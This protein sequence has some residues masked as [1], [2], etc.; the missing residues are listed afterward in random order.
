MSRLA[1]DRAGNTLAIV[2]AAL[3]PLTAM[4]GS[5]VDMSRA[6][7]AK[8]RL[9][10]A[11]DAA[12][13]AGRRVMVSDTINQEVRDEAI[14]FFNFNFA[15]GMYGT[16]AFTP[17]VTR[18]AVGTVRVEA[19]TTI[20]TTIMSLFGFTTIDLE[21]EC[22]ATQNFVNTDVMLVLDTT[23]SMLCTPEELGSCGRTS[24]IPESRI[25]VLRDAVMSLYEALEPAQTQLQA[26]GMRLRY[27]IVPYSSAVNVGALIRQ[28]NPAYL[29]DSVTYPSRVANYTDST[30]VN[31]VRR[32]E[33]EDDTYRQVAFDTSQFKLGNPVTIATN[34]GGTVAAQGSYS[35]QQLAT[36]ATGVSTTSVTWNGCIMERDTVST[37]TASSG[38]TIP[39]DA[40]DLNINL[41][42]NSDA[43]RWR[44]MWP[45]VVH[46]RSGGSTSAT[47]GTAMSSLAAAWY[48]CPS[49]ARRL[50]AMTQD[51]MQDYVDN[52][53]AVGGTYHD[54]GM[55]WGARLISPGGIF[56]DSPNTFNSMPVGRHIIF[57]TDGDLAPNC[58]SYTSYGIE[59]NDMR[60][61]GGGSCPQ[62]EPRHLQRFKMICNAAKGLNVSIWVIAFG[63]GTSLT[64]D[65]IDCASNPD[66]AST[67]DNRREL[68]DR[69]TLIGQ[70]IGALRLT[71]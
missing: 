61:T 44:P 31:G 37:I 7:M 69:F 70:N 34:D 66:Q 15:Q 14:E 26:A 65:L 13:L 41:I 68:I 28:A 57:M 36:A 40:Y 58:N 56:A 11:C 47:S 9:Q 51:E 4:I 8:T 52:L 59:Q 39:P 30:T 32:Y 12:A 46:R 6:Y 17:T 5:G 35:Q 18:P 22:D 20:P 29:A 16:A 48:A 60:V 21:V 2:G 63:N 62:Q 43:T 25:V 45:E 53:E 71:Q 19:D 27:G 1:R 3:V 23:G 50:G 54:I 33:Y 10:S 64:Q 67:A 55:L 38:L 42:P 24:E 49:P